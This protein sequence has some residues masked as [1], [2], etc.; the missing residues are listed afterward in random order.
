VGNAWK[1]SHAVISPFAGRRRERKTKIFVISLRQL[2][3]TIRVQIFCQKSQNA[4]G[5]ER[6]VRA[7]FASWMGAQ[8]LSA[9][10]APM[11]AFSARGINRAAS[12]CA[13][14]LFAR[15]DDYGW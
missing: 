12:R 5:R 3:P 11:G 10:L 4:F 6:A 15:G 13:P 14:R 8:F 9:G 2:Q 7:N 1:N